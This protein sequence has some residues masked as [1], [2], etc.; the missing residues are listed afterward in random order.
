[1]HFDTTAIH[2]GNHPDQATSAIAPPIV[3]STTFERTADGGM[4]HGFAYIRDGN[5]TQSRL[6]EALAAIDGA[7]CALAF[8]S[9]MA[10]AGAVL[11]ALPPGAHVLVAEDSYYGVRH[12]ADDFFARWQLISDYVAM[13][14]L[15]AV[16]GAIRPETKLLWAESPSNPLMRVCDLSALADVAHDANALLAVDGT[17]ASPALQRPI[18]H[19][20]DVVLH[21]TT[22]Y[23]GGH[24]D[25]QGGSLAFRRRDPFVEQVESVRHV[26]G[27]VASPFN[28]WLVLRGIKT[29]SA[30]MRVHCQNARAIAA[31]LE[32]HPRVEA[33]HYPGLA[34]HPGHE[35]AKRQ[36]SDFGGMLSFRMKGGREEAIAVVSRVKL[37]TVATSLGAIESLIEHRASSEGPGSRTPQNL[38]RMSVGLE[39]AQDLM[40]DLQQ[41]LAVSS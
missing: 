33:V 13:D 11:Q 5:P 25:V 36:M 31:F 41:A 26:V 20:A 22:K 18:E 37:F 27:G 10:A 32:A 34:S 29:L 2:A 15:D 23:L 35:I 6:E 24:S 19:G 12:F 4:P 17:F 30:R 28:S 8:A 14:D 9:G 1:M 38:V 39:H 3:L 7:E 40:D 21:S 16:R